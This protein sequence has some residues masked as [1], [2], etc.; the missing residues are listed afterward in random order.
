MALA[1]LTAPDLIDDDVPDDDGA[2]EHLSAIVPADAAG[3]RI[4]RV[5]ARLFPDHSR[6]RIQAW[7]DDARLRIDGQTAHARTRLRGGERAELAVT[8]DPQATA[9]APEPV[10]L[11]VVHEDAAVIIIDKTAG[12]VVHPAAGNWSGTVLNGLLH[13]YPEL[14]SVPRAGIVHR[15]DKDTTGLMVV[16]RTLAAQTD[17]VRQLQARTVSRRYL[18]V[19]WGDPGTRRC[20]GPIGRDPRERIRMAV[21]AGGKPAITHVQ[22][23]AV[24]TLHGRVVSLIECRLE[25]GRTHQIRVHLAHDGCALVGDG[26]YAPRALAALTMAAFARQALHARALRFVHP[27][28][29]ADFA[30]TSPLPADM[31]ALCASA[32]LPNEVA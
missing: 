1:S 19:C 25:T 18:A 6:A 29:G 11:N 17:L 10:A 32:G 14:A 16:A 23:L 21:V 15:L 31:Q 27:L 13:R 12:L 22:R 7:I 8:P 28:S 5:M 24:G 30:L 9:F 3:E 2:I 26:L 20:E 4:D